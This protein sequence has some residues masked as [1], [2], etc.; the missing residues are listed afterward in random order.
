VL[1]DPGSEGVLHPGAEVD[2][3]VDTGRFDEAQ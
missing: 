2:G 1:R 3:T